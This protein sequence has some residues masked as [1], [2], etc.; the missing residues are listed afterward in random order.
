MCGVGRAS[1]LTVDVDGRVYPCPV[2]A[3]SPCPLSIGHIPGNSDPRR[4]PD[5]VCAFHMLVGEYRERFPREP[6]AIDFL[7]GTDPLPSLMQELGRYVTSRGPR[8]DRRR[9]WRLP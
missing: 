6:D 4:I 5:F 7:T 1:A 9:A 2:D 3:C 8:E